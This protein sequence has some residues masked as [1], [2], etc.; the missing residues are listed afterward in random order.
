M[1]VASSQRL[2]RDTLSAALRSAGFIT[3]T[4]AVPTGTAQVHA[5]RRRI[6][7]IAPE[8][9]LLAADVYSAAD[10]REA[11]AVVTL[12]ELDWLLLTST[13][14]SA[15]W[16]A[17]IEA[18]VHD[19]LG[20]ATDLEGL[21]RALR[22]LASGRPPV[23]AHDHEEALRPWQD[24]PEDRRMLARRI[25]GLSPREMEILV[26]LH[27]GDSPK[28]IATRA[29]VSEGTVRTQV[30]SL[31]HKLAVRSQIQAVASYRDLNQWIAG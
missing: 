2:V 6:A 3:T 14:R 1:L 27:R 30:R 20:A 23:P 12:L 25:E 21:S 13:R 17:L 19:V 18:G 4:T 15:A 26:D 7:Q 16:G 31:M 8:V 5:T 9:G 28:T 24:G 11:A 10:L 22:Q 29:G